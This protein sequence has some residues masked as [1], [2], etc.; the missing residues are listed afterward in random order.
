ML[1]TTE[2][3]TAATAG[4]GLQ[5][6]DSN[7]YEQYRALSSLAV[8][9]AVL[10]VVG[11]LALLDWFLALI[12]LAGIVVSLLAMRRIR[13]SEGEL[14]G[15]PAAM[16]GLV[17]NLLLLPAAMGLHTY[18]YLT[19]VPPGYERIS[20]SSLQPDEQNPV[21]P[22]EPAAALD[23]RK[24]FIKG[25]ILPGAQDTNL[26]HFILVRDNGSCCFGAAEP[27]LTDKI[28]VR[29]TGELSLDYTTRQVK[30]AGTFHIEPAQ[31]DGGRAVIYHLLVD[32][33]K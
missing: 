33:A 13:Q 23:G 15:R 28:E 27:K 24:V 4:P 18:I 26:T 14:T 3:A 2:S 31:V 12:P 9:G 25:Y 29:L 16:V 22:P 1:E 32:Y 10:G 5:S 11:L 19:E 20:Y 8:A 21:L 30:L 6:F 17:L 7:D